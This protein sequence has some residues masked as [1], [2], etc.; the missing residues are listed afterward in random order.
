[1]WSSM[2]EKKAAW[3]LLL[4]GGARTILGDQRNKVRAGCLRAARVGQSIL[5]AGGDAVEAVEAVIRV[6]EDDPSFNAGTGAVRNAAGEIEMDAAIMDGEDLALGAVAALKDVRHPISVARAMLP[7]I[8]VLLAGAGAY[9]FARAHEAEPACEMRSDT[10]P[11]LNGACDTVGCVARDVRGEIA[12]GTSTGGLHGKM[13]GRVGDSPLAGSGL[14]ADSRTGGVSASGDGESIVRTM[15]A[16]RVMFEVE[17][18]DPQAA[19]EVALRA[20]ERVGGEAGLIV[21]DARGR[22]GIAHNSDHFALGYAAEHQQPR[23]ALHMSE[24]AAWTEP[25]HQ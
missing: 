18:G 13:P 14:Y 22:P 1:M 23:C 7:E 4:H 24:A 15:L 3:S 17:S 12:A 16:A 9:A 2:P 25:V 5:R 6:L 10:H 8:P 11:S 20:L 19:A 21:L